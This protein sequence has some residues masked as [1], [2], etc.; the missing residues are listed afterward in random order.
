MNTAHRP[1]SPDDDAIEREAHA[2]ARV[3]GAGSP[4]VQ[5]GEAF[6]AWRGQSPAHQRAWAQASRA[7]RELGGVVQAYAAERPAQA[8]PDRRAQ[9]P[10]SPRRRWLLAGGA[11]AFASLAAVGLLR[12]PLGLWPSYAE[13]QADYRTATGEQRHYALD[14]QQLTLALN[15]QTSLNVATRDGRPEIELVAGEAAIQAR[16]DQPC[17]VKAGAARLL[18]ADGDI[19]IRRLRGQQ[20]QLR[21]N[22]GQLEVR[23]PQGALRLAAGM[24]I[25]YDDDA[26][27]AP[28]PLPARPS[29][30]RAGVVSFHDLP[31]EQAIDE[32]NRYRPGRVVLMNGDLA[33]R[34]LSARY[35]VQD[36]DQAIAQ[37]QQLY[38]AQ[39]RRVGDLVFLS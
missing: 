12:P 15:T 33:R 25:A 39:V 11:G 24:Q 17:L 8:R 19:E 30:W 4:T 20:V 23:H 16:R 2:W 28:A 1:G 3:L 37:I 38:G 13:M 21:C 31:L 34:R 18:L 10:F 22:A 35:E 26:L 27:D 9:A 36:L 14:A 5:D 7:W 6:K 29:D 32:I